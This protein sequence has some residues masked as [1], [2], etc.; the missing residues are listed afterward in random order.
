MLIPLAALNLGW[1]F[2]DAEVR[3]KSLAFVPECGAVTG[4]ELCGTDRKFLLPEGSQWERV[5]D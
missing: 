5:V 2:R 3:H 4:H 1:P